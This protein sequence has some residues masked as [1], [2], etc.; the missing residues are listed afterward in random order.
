MKVYKNNIKFKNQFISFLKNQK[1]YSENTT[2]AYDIDINHLVDHIGEMVE[3]I[4]F[5]KYDLHEYISL[6]SN[7]TLYFFKLLGLTSKS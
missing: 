7:F 4:K 2:R 1:K 6:L 5:N 3:L